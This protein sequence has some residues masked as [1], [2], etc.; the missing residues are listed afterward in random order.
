M[1]ITVVLPHG[2]NYPI[3]HEESTKPFKSENDTVTLSFQ[4]DHSRNSKMNS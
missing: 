1:E 2:L 4:E 3:G